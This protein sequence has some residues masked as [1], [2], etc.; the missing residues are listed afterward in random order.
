[1]MREKELRGQEQLQNIQIRWN[2]IKEI[3][4][5]A[6]EFIIKQYEEVMIKN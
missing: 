2:E 3:M 6:E 5:I 1:M 4:V